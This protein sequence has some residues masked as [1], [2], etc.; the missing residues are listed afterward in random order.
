MASDRAIGRYRRWYGRLLRLYPRPFRH[1]FGEPMAQTFTDLAREH[2][3]PNRGLIG[4]IA[5]AFA[6]TSAGIIRENVTHMLIQ[7]NVLIRWG[8]SP[9]RSWRCHFLPWC[10]SS[11]S[12]IPAPAP[13]G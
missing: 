13:R 7:T 10:S 2:S 9:Q 11:L 4:F 12:P 5:W 8:S 6:E 1:R 3:D